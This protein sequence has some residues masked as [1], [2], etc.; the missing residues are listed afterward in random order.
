MSAIPPRFPIT[1]EQIDQ[2]MQ[3]FYTSV[4]R[5]ETL[6]PIFHGHIGTDADVWREHIAKIGSFWYKGLLRQGDYQGNPMSAHTKAGDIYSHHFDIWLGLFDAALNQVLP[7]ETAAQWSTLAHRMGK[8]LRMGVEDV[9]LP[10]GA[11]P[12]LG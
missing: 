10:K 8:G 4:R 6:G 1:A 9:H 3:V 11:V 12:I 7:E 2:V 5:D